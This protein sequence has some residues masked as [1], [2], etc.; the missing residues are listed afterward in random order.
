M[1]RTSRNPASLSESLQ[2]HLNSYAL[3]ASAAGVGMLALAQPAEAKIVYT[4]IHHVIG[5]HGTYHFSLNH[6]GTD[7]VIFEHGS[8]VGFTS[9]SV[10]GLGNNEVRGGFN[11]GLNKSFANRLNKSVVVSSK[12]GFAPGRKKGALMVGYYCRRECGYEEGSW[13]SNRYGYLGLKFKIGKQIHLGWARLTVDGTGNY[14]FKATLLGYAYET[15]PNKPIV[16]GKTKGP[17]VI[18]LDPGSLGVLAAGASGRNR[19]K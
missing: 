5:P 18:T 2:R 6:K 10:E 16:T 15:I 7:F 19:R 13:D 11:S 14:A 3:A 4:K 1:K 8:I 9:L 12:E 17:D